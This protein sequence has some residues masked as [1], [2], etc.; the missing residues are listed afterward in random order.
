MGFLEFSIVAL[1]ALVGHSSRA[2]FNSTIVRRI[3]TIVLQAV[4]GRRGD[5]E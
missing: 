1:V 3:R 2:V 4:F 5:F